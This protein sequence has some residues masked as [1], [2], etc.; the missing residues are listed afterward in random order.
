MVDDRNTVIGM[1]E[2]LKKLKK[3]IK[4]LLYVYIATEYLL[5]HQNLG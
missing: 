5:I 3:M 4:L 2:I 1:K